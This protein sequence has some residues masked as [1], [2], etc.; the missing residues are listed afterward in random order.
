ML[1]PKTRMTGAPEQGGAVDPGPHVLA[2]EVALRAFGQAEVVADR[3]ARDV[4]AQQERVLP[5]AV[6]VVV[7]N[8]LGEPVRGRL[9]GVEAHVGGEV[10]VVEQVHL[11]VRAVEQLAV[12]IGGQAQ[13]EVARARPADRPDGPRGPRQ[14]QGGRERRE[15]GSGQERPSGTR[16]HGTALAAGVGRIDQRSLS[17]GSSLTAASSSRSAP[18]AWRFSS[19]QAEGLLRTRRPPESAERSMSFG[20]FGSDCVRA[21]QVELDRDVAEGELLAEDVQQVPLVRLVEQRGAVD[22]QHD[23]RRRRADLGGVVDLGRAVLPCVEGGCASTAS[24]RTRFRVPVLTRLLACLNI[25][26]ARFSSALTFLPVLRGDE[27]QR[28]VRHRAEGVL[29]RDRILAHHRRRRPSVPS[30]IIRSHLLTV[31]MQGLYCLRDVVGEL[32]VEPG[33][34]LRRVEEQQ[35]DVGPADRPLGAVER[36]EVEVVADLGL[37][38]HARRC[39]WRRTA[40]RPARTARRRESRVVPGISETIIRSAWARVLMNVDLPVFGRP[41]TA[42]FITSSAGLPSRRCRGASRRSASGGRPCCGS[43]GPR[44]R[45]ACRGRA[46]RTPRRGRRARGSSALLM[47]RI[48]GLST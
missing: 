48:T 35:H 4:E 24:R 25:D 8:I 41:T 37:P 21:P 31:K 7:V 42:T 13:L 44:R 17:A 9:D 19:A 27:R 11:G 36:V 33:D 39:R 34:P 3:R 15:G 23:R 14:R 45:P 12:R 43:A 1:P 26:C 40:G 16:G 38:A 46:C 29:D 5:Q 18:S 22:E 6:Q 30:P 47:T 10:H 28:H 20:A 32:L 2:I